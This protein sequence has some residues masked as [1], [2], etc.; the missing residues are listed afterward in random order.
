M[1]LFNKNLNPF[2]AKTVS[3]E[4]IKKEL[5][6]DPNN[7]ELHLQL[8]LLIMEKKDEMTYGH[9]AK[10]SFLTAV[11]LEPLNPVYHFELGNCYNNSGIWKHGAR[12]KFRTCLYMGYKVDECQKLIEEINA[13]DVADNAERRDTYLGW[14][15]DKPDHPGS[16]NS[17]AIYHQFF[18][19]DYPK[20][21]EYAIKALSLDAESTEGLMNAGRAY[22]HLKEVDKAVSCFEKCLEIE[23]KKHQDDEEDEDE[24]EPKIFYGPNDQDDA[25]DFELYAGA[26][27]EYGEYDGREQY[28]REI[29]A[30]YQENKQLD[31]AIEWLQKGIKK[32]PGTTFSY[33]YLGECY[34]EQGENDLAV[35]PFKKA[36]FLDPEG[37]NF[38]AYDFLIQYYGSDNKLNISEKYINEAIK[39]NPDSYN[40]YFFKGVH[41]AMTKA[42]DDA[43][44]NYLIS[45]VFKPD[46]APAYKNL[47]EVCIKTNQIDEGITYL[48]NGLKVNPEMMEIHANLKKLYLKKGDIERANFHEERKQEI[49]IAKLFRN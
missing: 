41:A 22:G 12:T 8:G 45:L 26:N 20:S 15:R 38:R 47:C 44:N 46:F 33:L 9:R 32:F 35:L 2:S 28:Y 49:E 1:K 25:D 34:S 29:A 13:Y 14:L 30:V 16:Y 36:I 40:F 10:E 3:E 27:D 21:L 43:I 18:E 39:N 17:M 11:R 42:Y 24:Q 19:L 4:S 31:K 48:L 23:N 6:R 7:P 5:K 37:E